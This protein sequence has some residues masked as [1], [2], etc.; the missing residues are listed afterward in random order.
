M[1]T[2][3]N[4][5]AAAKLFFLFHKEYGQ[6]FKFLS[7]IF[8]DATSARPPNYEDSWK[9][10]QLLWSSRILL[11]SI[12][13]QVSVFSG[14]VALFWLLVYLF[15]VFILFLQTYS[16]L[17]DYFSHPVVVTVSIETNHKEIDFP[18]V[19]LCNNNIVKKS[20]ISRIPYLQD[21]AFLDSYTMG[22]LIANV[23]N[24]ENVTCSETEEFKCQTKNLCI[25]SVWVCNG[26]S[27]CGDDSDES[28]KFDCSNHVGR[29]LTDTCASGLIQCPGE[30]V[31]AQPCDNVDECTVDPGYDE[32]VYVG[33]SNASDW[34]KNIPKKSRETGMHSTND[35]IC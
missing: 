34:L 4:K 28:P 22:S 8:L 29:N 35:I 1:S 10:K 21:L 17:A 7:I 14:P 31:C 5:K 24:A 16:T 11:D 3:G 25:P 26:I 6:K 15:F 23:E 2:F 32:S 12:M 19:T 20:M 13:P 18:A 27:E 30:T 9:Q 33:Q